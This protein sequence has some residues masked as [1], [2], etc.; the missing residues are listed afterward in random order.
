M[1]RVL[2]SIF[3]AGTV[4]GKAQIIIKTDITDSGGNFSYLADSSFVALSS[5]T[6]EFFWFTTANTATIQSWLQANDWV[7]SALYSNKL[8]QISL[9][10][11]YD[12]APGLF[13]GE[14]NV[15][16]LPAGAVGQ[17]L[18]LAVTAGSALGVFQFQGVL[19]ANQAAGSPIPPDFN[20]SL[21]DVNSGGV[22]VGAFKADGTFQYGGDP[23][24]G[25]AYAL[26]A[27][28]SGGGGGGGGTPVIP[29]PSSFSL[30]LLG[31]TGLVALRRLRR[32]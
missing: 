24:P 1:K 13:A 26:L 16:S 21:A 18:G 29:E 2:L 10:A 30:L 19:P 11:G 28:S 31:G 32:V 5:G 7:S 8:G 4:I 15:A 3:L 27:A 12:N 9:G 17:K 14:I 22:L 25:E 20:V 6:L 23:F